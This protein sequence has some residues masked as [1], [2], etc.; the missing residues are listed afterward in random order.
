M[1]TLGDDFCKWEIA[2][3]ERIPWTARGHGYPRLVSKRV[4]ALTFNL[5]LLRI[6]LP[7]IRPILLLI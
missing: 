5:I 7:L 2:V 6:S 3:G 4:G 1:Y